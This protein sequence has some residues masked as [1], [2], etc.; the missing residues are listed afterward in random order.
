[1]ILKIIYVK[2]VIIYI[3]NKKVKYELE[4]NKNKIKEEHLKCF[5]EIKNRI[6]VLQKINYFDDENNYY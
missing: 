3:N 5:S 6:S 2:N 1:M 4:I